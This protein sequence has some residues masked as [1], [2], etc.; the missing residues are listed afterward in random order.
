M[1]CGRMPWLTAY[2]QLLN[3]GLG[4]MGL[5]EGL[6]SGLAGSLEHSIREKRQASI[7]ILR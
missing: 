1:L 7:L 4:D 6:V 2:L 5:D 3:I